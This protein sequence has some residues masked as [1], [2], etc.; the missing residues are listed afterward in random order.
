M[1]SNEPEVRQI[2]M[3]LSVPP[4]QAE[5]FGSAMRQWMLRVPTVYFLDICAISHIKD[6]LPTQTLKDERHKES[7]QALQELD[8]PHNGVS[9]LPAL[10][11]KASD[12]RSKFSVQ[13]FI[14]EARRDWVA[15]AAFFQ[16]APV[17]EPWDFVEAYATDLFGAH[18]EESAS[19]YLA[20]LQ[21]ANDQRLHNRAADGKRLNIARV[22]CAKAQELGIITSHPVVLVTI[23]CVYGCEDA[24]RVMKF[25]GNPEK[26]NPGN[27]LGDVQAI[28]RIAGTMASLIQRDGA[29][30]GPFKN[31]KFV[32]ADSPLHNMLRYFTVQSVSTT[33]V[34]DGTE[35]QIAMSVSA[36]SLYPD[37][38]DADGE[39]KGEKG[40]AELSQLSDLL[41]VEFSV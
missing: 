3:R 8:L 40:R 35:Q 19:A 12:Q 27:A 41:G 17:I 33:D 26:F 18:P 39:P 1:D 30:G 5:A 20:F 28:S 9:Y 24:Q 32:T 13:E 31:G 6:Y 29:R 15:M 36:P 4:D 37:L 7:I 22:L 38:F 14:A 23:A 25:A 21:Y 2:T 34:P 10:M 11:E 16:S